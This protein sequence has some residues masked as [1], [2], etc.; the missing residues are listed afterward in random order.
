MGVN[1]QLKFGYGN[2]W[3]GEGGTFT[4]TLTLNASGNS[5]F[6]GDINV[7]ANYIGRD[8][9][10]MVDFS[11][12]NQMA[13]RANNASRVTIDAAQMYPNT[14]NAYNLGHGSYRWNNIY[15][16]DGSVIDFNGDV[17]LT[18]SSNTLTLTGGQLTVSGEIE[19]TS[20]DI[21]GNADISGGTTVKAISATKYNQTNDGVP[22]NNLGS[23]T[24]TEMALFENQ[25]KPQTTLANSYNDLADLT[26]FTRATG[27][28]E[29]DYAEVTSYS[30]DQKRRFL[31]TNNSTV[32]IPNSHNS[33]RV[34]FVAYG[35][36]FANAMVAYWSSQSHNTQVHV[37]KRRC[38][39]NVWIQHTSSA[40]TVSSWPG[41]MYLPF[42]TI[43]W[44]ETN[45]TSTGHYNKIRI[46][47]TP[48]WSTYSGSGT[49]YSGYSIPIYGMQIWG[50]YPS[51]RRTV[52][53]Y[54]QNGKLNLFGDINV[55]GNITTNGTVD[56]VD[57]SALPTAFADVDAE[58]NVQSDWNATSG[59]A[60]ILNKPTIPAAITDYVSK[61]NGGTFS[62]NILVN[63][64]LA[65]N[66][67]TVNAANKLEVHGQARV[68]GKMMIGDSSISNV[69]NAA[70]QLHVKNTGQAGIRLED[71]DSSNLA[72]DVIVDEGVGFLIK[73][74]VGGDSGDDVRLTI[75]ESTG[76]VTIGGTLGSGAITST[77]K[78]SGT[79][80]EGTSLDINGDADISGDLTGVDN[81]Y[82]TTFRADNNE[83]YY[84]KDASGAS[85]RLIRYGTDD[86]VYIGNGI[87]ELY[88]ANTGG[89]RQV[90]HTG[91][92]P[93]F[94]EI[95]TTPTTIAGY[96]IT[97]ALVIGTTS[98]TAMAGN[99]TIPT[100]HGDH[101]G[102]YL[103]IGGG[104]LTGALTIAP[105]TG[106]NAVL[107][108]NGDQDSFIEKDTGNDLYIANNANNKDIKFRVKDD[109]TNVIAL[110][111]D[112]SENGNASFTG[113]VKAANVFIADDVDVT[114]GT[115]ATGNARF[116]GYGLN[117]NRG[118]FYITNGGGT[119]QIGNGTTHN[120]SPTATFSSTEITFARNTNIGSNKYTLTVNAPTSLTTSVV[121]D[122]INVTFTASTTSNVDNYLIFSSVAG[123]DYGLISV[124]PPADFGAT[125]SI[126]DDSF[127]AGG[128]QAYRVYAVKNG[129][130][131]S[132]LTGSQTFTVGTVEP[133]NLSVINLNTAYYIQY[134]APSAKGR[135]VA[136]YNI[137]KHEHATA[138]SLARASAS[139]V[140]S[141]INNSY[142]YGISG[143]DNNNFHQFWVEVTTT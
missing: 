77:G 143:V 130:Y 139:L 99:T 64:Q 59:D 23:P 17:S 123:G 37:W 127:N 80:L 32:A 41:H 2:S 131:S 135:F 91:H 102:L 69:P 31:R 140:Y 103:P 106:L 26:F 65:V 50:G 112:G 134:D 55:P 124:I 107:N 142:M 120:A 122:T 47:F 30:D 27:T 119:V 9:T 24:V 52:H 15:F 28:S 42:S 20:L 51:G 62:G 79:E 111:L 8:S 7:G 97:D 85:R 115:P 49:D 13:F 63:A 113:Q 18:H 117:G 60:L 12:D 21:N 84:A 95:A 86:N 78:I 96:G 4:P 35:Y 54:D 19:A 61:A 43:G 81:S 125:M 89:T 66:S 109:T 46:E 82:A 1:G 93:T 92:F 83:S 105:A 25:F 118:A 108:I 74:T 44:H 126:I 39:D 22:R 29:S 133:T 71:S 141:G 3:V 90:F 73:E 10:D 116:S 16:G 36:S 121:N 34:E 67:T 76:A 14:T 94:A 100:D 6:S 136:S 11:T 110:T 138:S 129:V 114:N 53:S 38:S 57:I 104:S 88:F 48:N 132:P 128:T 98:T 70:V 101:D 72:F 75:A 33:F 5:T 58:Q 45:T 68:N 40:T 137:Y 56:G 87:G